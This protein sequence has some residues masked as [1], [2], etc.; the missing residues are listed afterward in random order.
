MLQVRRNFVDCILSKWQSQRAPAAHLGKLFVLLAWPAMLLVFCTATAWP[1]QQKPIR[2]AIVNVAKLKKEYKA[3]Q[4][5]QSELYRREQMLANMLQELS[6]YTFLS[7]ELFREMVSI[8]QLPKPWPED[9]KKRA[10]DLRRI[11][12]EKQKEYLALRANTKRTPQQEDRFK[13]LQELVE[14]RQADLQQLRRQHMEELLKLQRTYESELIQHIQ[15][16]I[17]QV[18]KEKNYD[19]VFDSE[20]VF[21]GGDDITDAVV[22]AL[23]SST[24]KATQGNKSTTEGANK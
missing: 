20:V 1:Q 21:F 23:N 2:I 11:S 8:A 14:A 17:E 4:Q 15:Q 22:K 9:K 18:A 5:R 12:E 3:F 24:P 10:E 19:Y 16:T 7:S 6:Q 13:S